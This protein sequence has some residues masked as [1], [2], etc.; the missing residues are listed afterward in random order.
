MPQVQERIP[1]RYIVMECCGHNVCHVNHRFPIYCQE[2]GASVYPQ[3]KGWVTI[4]DDN[5]RLVYDG[6]KRT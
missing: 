6:D 1:F 3:V 2:C 4:H 5:A